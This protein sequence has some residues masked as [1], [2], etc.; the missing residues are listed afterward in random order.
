MTLLEQH[1]STVRPT[2]LTNGADFSSGLPD[3]DA[4]VGGQSGVNKS[5]TGAQ[6]KHFGSRAS[7]HVSD[8]AA[9]GTEVICGPVEL[10]KYVDLSGTQGIIPLTSVKL[11]KAKSKLFL[12]H[13]KAFK[14]S[15]DKVSTSTSNQV[16]YN[17]FVHW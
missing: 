7:K 3:V 9:Q 15:R 16:N 4:S 10:A 11:L 14:P 2:Q 6:S 17:V 8:P 12:L 13:L 1:I 5:Q